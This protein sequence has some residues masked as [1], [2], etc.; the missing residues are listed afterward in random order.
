MTLIYNFIIGF[1]GAFIGVIPPGLLNMSA[2]KISMK[3]GRRRGLLFSAGV[4]LTVMVQTFVALVFARFLD[5]HPQYIDA[6]Q[7]VALGIFICL[8][9]YFFFIARDSRRPVPEDINHSRANRFF[10]GMF[11]AVINLLP[12]PYWVYVGITFSRFKWFSFDQPA[13]WAA[14][15]ASG[16]GTFLMLVLYIQYFHNKDRVTRFNVNMNYVIGLITAII[17]V[18]TGI[19]IFR[20]F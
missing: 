15:I 10:Y 14:V 12:L 11:L 4:C 16:L 18:V 5:G 3:A 8:T 20:D 7:K 1:L 2:A 6:L 13:I 9:L 17:S 19:K